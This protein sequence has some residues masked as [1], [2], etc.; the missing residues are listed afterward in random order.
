MLLIANI[1][2]CGGQNRDSGMTAGTPS[3][4]V[5]ALSER[6]RQVLA[7]HH[8]ELGGY[9]SAVVV[10]SGLDVS[11]EVEAAVELLRS[12]INEHARERFE[13]LITQYLT[14]Q[15]TTLTR[16]E[17]MRQA[18]FRQRVI[19]EHGG[20]TASELADMTGSRA[21]NRYRLASGW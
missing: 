16:Q 19:S 18:R 21:R 2:L 5:V 17:A 4:A 13:A 6:E 20:Y 1:A 3:V 9:A 12:S 10:L 8:P 14:E 15:P 11:Q 7:R